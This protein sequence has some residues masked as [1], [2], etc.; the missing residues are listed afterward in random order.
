MHHG[1]RL[2]PQAG[3]STSCLEVPHAGDYGCIHPSPP[4][5]P[6]NI[7]LIRFPNKVKECREATE[8]ADTNLGRPCNA[9]ATLMGVEELSSQG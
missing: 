5:L 8:I 2:K 4:G 7:G 1:S 6:R 9:A 3:P